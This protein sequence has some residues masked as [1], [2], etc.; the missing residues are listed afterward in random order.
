[1]HQVGDD[2]TAVIKNIDTEN[3]RVGLSIKDYESGSDTETTKDYVDNKE[4]ITSSLGKALANL[5]LNI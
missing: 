5:K 1:M 2:V 4:K 3:K